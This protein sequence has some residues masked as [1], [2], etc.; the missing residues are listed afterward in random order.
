MNLNPLLFFYFVTSFGSILGMIST[1]IQTENTFGNL[2]HLAWALSLRTLVSIISSMNAPAL[3]TRF[4]F[5]KVLIT[6]EVFGIISLGFLF[7]GVSIGNF[8]IS[9]AALSIL[10]IP[11]NL[12]SQ[13]VISLVKLNCGEDQKRFTSYSAQISKTMG[14]MDIVICLSAPILLSILDLTSIY[15]I[16]FCSYIIGLGVLFLFQGHFNIK[17]VKSNDSKRKISYD[18]W[19]KSDNLKYFKTL[20]GTMALIGIV[21]LIA[22]SKDFLEVYKNSIPSA[23]YISAI[24]A[25]EGIG[26]FLSGYIYGNS[27]L[28]KVFKPALYL[29]IG[30]I[31]LSAYTGSYLLLILGCIWVTLSYD[32]IF[33]F[34]RDEALLAAGNDQEKVLATASSFSIIKSMFCTLSPIIIV[35]VIQKTSII[36]ALIILFSMQIII[37]VIANAKN[38]NI[39]SLVFNK[40]RAVE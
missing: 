37:L 1:F 18:F 11:S 30:F 39:Q 28:R 10:A 19:L 33:K 26:F 9:V 31:L 15:F 36:Q 38:G 27:E 20:F 8:V 24:W 5:K 14:L 4:G 40:P 25:T 34:N 6:S 13:G 22:G 7:Y 21:P 29:S 12:L 23:N 16:D 3:Y 2:S 32:V 35:F 17:G